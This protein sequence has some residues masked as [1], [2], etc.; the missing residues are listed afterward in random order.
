ML[1]FTILFLSISMILLS[2]GFAD[3]NLNQETWNNI[4]KT[5]QTNGDVK[6][7]EVSLVKLSHFID[8]WHKANLK[9]KKKKVF[10]LQ[11]DIISVIQFDIRTSQKFISHKEK[12]HLKIKANKNKTHIKAKNKLGKFNSILK[13]KKRLL[14][15]FTRTSSF[16]NKL[17]LLG[18]YQELM[19]RELDL[20]V[21]RLAED[22]KGLVDELPEEHQD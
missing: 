20:S 6:Q 16:S 22:W 3:D 19:R 7:T 12:Q 11:R 14:G 17:R 21:V 18:D 8:L 10:Y 4:I 9:G 13:A 1:R 5:Q 2:F 15:S